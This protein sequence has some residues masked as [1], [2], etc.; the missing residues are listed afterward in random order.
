[1]GGEEFVVLAVCD[2][3][4]NAESIA[5]R[6]Q[7]A[8]SELRIRHT[9]SSVSDR[10]T[11]SQGIAQWQ[12]DMPLDRLLEKADKALYR[13]KREGRNRIVWDAEL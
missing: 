3:M 12:Q 9:G 10:V 8:L 11:V 4:S 5:K 1:L 13:A 2:T 7:Y 6:I